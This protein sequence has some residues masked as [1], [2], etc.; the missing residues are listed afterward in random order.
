Q[1]PGTSSHR[2]Q[3]IGSA[4]VGARHPRAGL[5][6]RQGPSDMTTIGHSESGFAAGRPQ[7]LVVFEQR[8]AAERRRKRLWTLLQLGLFAI[9]LTGS[10]LVSDFNLNGLMNG[11]PN[12][13]NYVFGTFP[14]LSIETLGAD[15]ADWY[16]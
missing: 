15:L 14:T 6:R 1:R 2:R 16:W 11:L 13:W 7:R 8:F 9:A 10:I 3:L 4:P 12:A 5:L